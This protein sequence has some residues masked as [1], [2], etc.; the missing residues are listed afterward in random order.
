[1]N[2]KSERFSW[3]KHLE[4]FNCLINCLR[5]E[6]DFCNLMAFY[7]LLNIAH[8]SENVKFLSNLKRC[9]FCSNWI[10]N[11]SC[12]RFMA[13]LCG[14]IKQR[15][16]CFQTIGFQGKEGIQAVALQRSSSCTTKCK[17]DSC[18]R[19]EAVGR[20]ETSENGWKRIQYTQCTA[21]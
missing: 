6:I 10:G 3:G 7:T 14:T 9:C 20:M 2:G 15:L 8:A 13:D 16:C 1:M 19:Q 11:S 17:T 4:N 21:Y 5:D 18:P 12:L